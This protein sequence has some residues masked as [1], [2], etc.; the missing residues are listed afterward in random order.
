LTMPDTVVAWAKL[1]ERL[2][3]SLIERLRDLAEVLRGPSDSEPEP[4][5]N[6]EARRLDEGNRGIG[7]PDERSG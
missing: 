3:A 2:P 4:D 5:P 1:P 7:A 6:P